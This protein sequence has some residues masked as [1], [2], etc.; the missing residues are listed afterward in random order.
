MRGGEQVWFKT[1]TGMTIVVEVEAP[2]IGDSAQTLTSKSITLDVE[3][4]GLQLEDGRTLSNYRI[5]KE[6]TFH[7]VL[8]L[9]KGGQI[10]IFALVEFNNVKV[11]GQWRDYE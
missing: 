5:Q 6:S 3:V 10:L 9:L 4:A 7:L 1:L 8:R 11:S 2:G